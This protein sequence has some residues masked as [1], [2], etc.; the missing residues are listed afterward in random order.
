MMTIIVDRLSEIRARAAANGIP[1][2]GEG[3]MPT[4]NAKSQD[5]IYIRGA[6]GELIEVIG[7]T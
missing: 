6:V 7:R 5:G 3:A 4:P 2:L 1:I